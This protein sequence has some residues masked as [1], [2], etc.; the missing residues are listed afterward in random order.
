MEEVGTPARR[1]RPRGRGLLPRPRT[2][3]RLATYL[4]MEL[5][6]L[7][8]MRQRSLETLSHTA[9][10]VGHLAADAGR[11]RLCSTPPT[12][13][14]CRCSAIAAHPG[15]DPRRRARVAACQVGRGRS[16]LLPRGRGARGALVRR[17]DR[18]RARASRL[19]P[20]RVRRR[21]PRYI[22][23]GAPIVD[24]AGRALTSSTSSPAAT[25]S[26]WHGSSRR[27]TCA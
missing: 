2:T 12:R 3:S 1:A 18:R 14:S 11:R 10:S 20:R 9:L 17:A 22:A 23:Y 27:T 8:A 13:R 6:Q 25:T 5:V 15:G 24:R 26:S 21:D 19:L 4:G 16:A 7:P